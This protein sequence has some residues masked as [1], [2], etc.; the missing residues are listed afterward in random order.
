M[1]CG[2][3]FGSTLRLSGSQSV[4]SADHHFNL[5]R[6]LLDPFAPAVARVPNWDLDAAR[7]YDASAPQPDLVRSTVDNAGAMPKCVFTHDDFD[8]G[9][10]EIVYGTPKTQAQ[11]QLFATVGLQ[12]YIQSKM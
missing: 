11:L 7:G 10:S 9:G 4:P 8:W 5:N 6:L 1:G 12:N 2:H 3:T